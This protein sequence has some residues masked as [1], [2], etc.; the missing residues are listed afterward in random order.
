MA[1][2]GETQQQ[3]QERART[4]QE[5]ESQAKDYQARVKVPQEALRSPK[6][7]IGMVTR[8]SPQLRQLKIKKVFLE[9]EGAKVKALEQ[10][11][12]LKK[13][14]EL[15]EQDFQDYLESEAGKTQ[16]VTETGLKGKP[17]Y[18]G[19]G[20]PI[21]AI[22]ESGKESYVK[23]GGKTKVA[24]VDV[25]KGYEYS[26]PYGNVFVPLSG[27][28]AKKEFQSISKSLTSQAQEAV[29]SLIDKPKLTTSDIVSIRG[30]TLPSIKAL[31][32]KKDEGIPSSVTLPEKRNEPFGI[33][34]ISQFLSAKKRELTSSR[35]PT[36]ELSMKKKLGLTGL[37]ALG[38][39]VG[40]AE[41]IASQDIKARLGLKNPL[42]RASPQDVK[43]LYSVG[44]SG[45]SFIKSMR[46]EGYPQVGRFLYENPEYVTGFAGAS[47]AIGYGPTAIAEGYNFLKTPIKTVV[48]EPRVVRVPARVVGIQTGEITRGFKLGGTMTTEGLIESQTR[49]GKL[50]RRT[51]SYEVIPMKIDVATDVFKAKGVDVTAQRFT[52]RFGRGTT[53]KR[54]EQIA[55]ISKPIEVT[56]LAKLG[57]VERYLGNKLPPRALP[58]SARTS[59]GV[60]RTFKGRPTNVKGLRQLR[61]SAYQDQYLIPTLPDSKVSFTFGR[62]KPVKT[63]GDFQIY[64]GETATKTGKSVSPRAIGKVDI[65]QSIIAIKKMDLPESLS[66]YYIKKPQTKPLTTQ[67]VSKIASQLP[68]SARPKLPKIDL[69]VKKPISVSG[70]ARFTPAYIIGT[71]QASISSAIKS[72]ITTSIPAQKQEPVLME[73]LTSSA[74]V[75]LPVPTPT[76]LPTP[77]NPPVVSD[78]PIMTQEI[79]YFEPQTLPRPIPT[80]LPTP[81][82]EVTIVDYG[83][84]SFQKQQVFGYPEPEIK[85]IT[86]LGNPSSPDSGSRYK[87]INII[88]P[89]ESS[90]SLQGTGVVTGQDMISGIK[91]SSKALNINLLSPG[92]DSTQAQYQ[93]QVSRIDQG[94][95][96]AQA[97]AQRTAQRTAMATP[98]PFEVPQVNQP[99]RPRGPAEIETGIGIALPK[100]DDNRRKKKLGKGIGGGLFMAEIRR[101]GKWIP[102]ASSPSF[103]E[104]FKSGIF[105]VRQTLAASL[106]IK[107][108]EKI[109]PIGRET[110]MFRPAKRNPTI[111][112][113]KRTFRLGTRGEKSEILRAKRAKQSF[114]F[115]TKKVGGT[116][117]FK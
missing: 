83:A 96:L 91:T 28:A 48:T 1:T 4:I 25:L 9:R 90:V 50:L 114:S 66:K 89:A 99:F 36:G 49:I 24:R 51:P 65:E 60:S 35:S 5:L 45:I 31:S 33:G 95:G 16:Y 79:S 44:K 81:P 39:A 30:Y 29:K 113:Q 7:Q 64:V 86:L 22:D 8:D 75:N 26:T 87:D 71:G 42:I 109:L 43:G 12:A 103:K 58:E 112:V 70:V 61:T 20:Q 76:P 110:R 82:R 92:Q 17:V 63:I 117:F 97:S 101:K 34:R 78:I 88:A 13:E 98:S 104:A 111:L 53:L 47:A 21:K 107:K 55:G 54:F 3:L 72:G 46:G 80:P 37:G 14:Q 27:S 68:P 52:Q 106:R 18:E 41:A 93:P 84:Q 62:T 11:G 32:L 23:S 102:V 115:K 57:K 59:L 2:I 67:Q 108:G 56:D 116:K 73:S 15:L 77:S 74:P 105:S 85:P 6:A 94:L 19:Y 40:T 38:A 10:V 100:E 69:S